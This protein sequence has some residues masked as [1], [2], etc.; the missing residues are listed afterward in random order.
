LLSLR[1][2]PLGKL[3]VMMF[4]AI[5]AEIGDPEA[6]VFFF[7]AHRTMFGG[8]HISVGDR[9]FIFA[10]EST[11]GQ[12]LIAF[13][14]VTSATALPKVHMSR[15]EFP[16]VTVSIARQLK[17]RKPLGRGTLK[18]FRAWDDGQ[19]ATELNAKF[20]R[21]PANKIAAIS[22]RTAAFLEEFF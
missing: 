7:C 8:K 22:A 12:G 2:T 5:K 6:E 13:G 16:C 17:A 21:Q 11:G 18:P 4:Y 19:P 15:Y 3:G 1:A 9:I 14:V 20:Y 10:N